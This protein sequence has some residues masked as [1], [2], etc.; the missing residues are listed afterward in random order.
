V[1]TGYRGN[2]PFLASHTNT[3]F[4]GFDLEIPDQRRA[5]L[6]IAEFTQLAQ[7]GD[8]PRLM[9]MRLPNDHT[10]GLR[11]GSPSPRAQM[12]DNDLALGRIVETVSASSVWRE[13]AIFVVEDDAQNGP[14]HVDS[15][16]SVLLT[17][18]PWA[19]RGVSHR[20]TNTTDV[21]ATIEEILG[22][23][24]LSQFDFYG[25]PLRGIWRE[26]PDMAAYHALTPGVPLS[27]R[28][29]ETG[30][31]ARESRR[32]EL[33][34]EDEADEVLFNHILWRAIK[35]DA[36]PYPGIRRMGTVEW[37]RGW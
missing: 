8:V 30:R 33:E 25:R 27:E 32:L 22:L 7:R 10:S 21:L 4:P 2:K 23:T 5:D 11:A 31:G 12:A 16:R 13:T 14:D 36:V 28:N 34:F 24:A 35:G 37:K 17:I 1:P 15:H 26:T 3:E 9:I 6:F 20:F 18:S 29:P 19:R